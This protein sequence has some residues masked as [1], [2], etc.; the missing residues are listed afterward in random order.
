MTGSE[1][2]KTTH[3]QLLNITTAKCSWPLRKGRMSTI[4]HPEVS[5]ADRGHRKTKP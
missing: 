4:Q 5:P 2:V 3:K 1:I